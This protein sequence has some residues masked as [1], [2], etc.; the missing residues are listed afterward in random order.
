[1]TFGTLDDQSPTLR[2]GGNTATTT[3]AST[4]APT[5]TPD[6]EPERIIVSGTGTQLAKVH[7]EKGLAIFTTYHQGSGTCEI[8]FSDGAKKIDRLVSTSTGYWGSKAEP[9]PAEGDYYLDV[10]ATDAW[11][12]H[13]TQPRP[14]VARNAPVSLAGTGEQVTDFFALDTGL[15][16]FEITH[17]GYSDFEIWLYDSYGTRL[18]RLVSDYGTYNGLCMANISKRGI[19]LMSV[20]ADGHWIVNVSQ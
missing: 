9:I 4:L 10:S 14:H 5:P 16:T 17:D 7:L 2:P 18:E 11:S 6:P 15:A 19:F 12:V 3:P 1:M 20:L 8:W 13:I